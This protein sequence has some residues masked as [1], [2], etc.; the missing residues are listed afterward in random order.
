MCSSRKRSSTHTGRRLV[1]NQFDV[2]RFAC[3]TSNACAFG[4]RLEVGAV[5]ELARHDPLSMEVLGRVQL[6]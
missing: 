5:V 1:R 4:R 2:L 6:L 3:L